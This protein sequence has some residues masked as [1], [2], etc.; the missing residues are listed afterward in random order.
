MVPC[1]VIAPCQAKA[2]FRLAQDQCADTLYETSTSSD[3]ILAICLTAESAESA[4]I[5]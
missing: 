4:E 3:S 2:D 5:I 1:R